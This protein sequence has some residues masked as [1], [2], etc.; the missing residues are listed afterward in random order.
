MLTLIFG[1]MYAGKSKYLLKYATGKYEAYIPEIDT[2]SG[3]TIQSRD[4]EYCTANKINENE[5][6]E[7]RCETIIV[8]EGQFLTEKQILTLKEISKKKDVYIGALDTDFKQ[9]PFPMSRL[10]FS[11]ADRVIHL[12]S[13]CEICG[14]ENATMSRRKTN[15]KNLIEIGSDDYFPICPNCM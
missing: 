8:D 4:G 2:R 5:D 7:T 13:K 12:T 11:V 14:K 10:L 6:F 9:E 15:S 1:P 3:R